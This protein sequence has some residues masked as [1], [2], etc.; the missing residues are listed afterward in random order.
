MK[1][2][3]A[4]RA[5]PQGRDNQLDDDARF[6]VSQP[7]EIVF[8]LKKIMQNT[9]LVTAYLDGGADFALT[10]LLAVMSD[11]AEV[12]LDVSPDA[13]ANKRLLAAKKVLLVTSHDQVK[14]K[15]T[16][17]D[18]REV[19]YQGR[20]A[21]RIPL[22]GTLVRIQ[23]REHYRI[24]TPITKPLI[25]TLPLPDRGA[26]VQAETI[27]LDISIGGVALMDNHDATGFQIG[28]VFKN[29]RI[30]LPE[31]G[32]LVVSLEVRNSFDTPLKNGLSFRRCGCQFL[33]LAPSNENLVQR[34][35]MF[36]ERSRNFRMKK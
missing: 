8:V 16:T 31:V 25:C 28:D 3:D 21:L 14:V 33:N 23:R 36:L 12:V 20:P 34:Y 35:I 4:N 9:Q 1:Q 19:R 2:E 11:T 6:A 26:G 22:P 17:S 10:S 13:A 7:A 29:C 32:T 5:Q 24:A 30:G 15:F 18:I 27:V